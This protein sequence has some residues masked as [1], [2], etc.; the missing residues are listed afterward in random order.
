MQS[1]FVPTLISSSEFNNQRIMTTVMIHNT[2]SFAYSIIDTI[3][4]IN[5]YIYI[6]LCIGNNRLVFFCRITND[7]L[8]AA[9]NTWSHLNLEVKVNMEY[10]TSRWMRIRIL[11]NIMG[12]R[13]KYIYWLLVWNM[14]FIFSF[15]GNFIIPTDELIFFREV[16]QPPTSIYI[17]IDVYPLVN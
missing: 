3:T 17:I 12:I 15:I 5:M 1:F 8:L 7:N 11:C 14:N 4:A 9:D 6:I 2:T 16:G 13:E 10:N